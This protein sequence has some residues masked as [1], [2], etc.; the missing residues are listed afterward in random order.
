MTW[1]PIHLDY[2]LN[3]YKI[4]DIR[5]LST[6]TLWAAI[7]FGAVWFSITNI[8]PDWI[9]LGKDKNRIDEVFYH[10]SAITFRTWTTFLVRI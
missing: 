3:H 5:V 4:Y 7:I 1:R 8:S 10:Q 6:V 2:I 9:V